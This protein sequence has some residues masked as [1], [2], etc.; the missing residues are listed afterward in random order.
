MPTRRTFLKSAFATFG[1]LSGAEFSAFATTTPKNFEGKDVFDRILRKAD[2]WA[3]LPIGELMGKI[4][5]E[6]EGTPYVAGS[7]ELSLDRE[8]CSVN[9]TGLDCVTFFETTLDFA[10]MIKKGGRTPEDLLKQVEFTRYRGGHRGDYS[11]RL[12]Y[13][14]DWLFDNQA[15]HTVKILD[16]L[17]GSTPYSPHVGFMSDHPDSYKQL[18]KHPAL[19][20]KLK[21]RENIINSRTLKFVPIDKI[22]EAAPSLKTG[23]IVGVCTSTPGLDITHTGL[24]VCDES[25]VPRFMHASSLKANYKVMVKPDLLPAALA[26]TKTNTGAMFARPLE[27]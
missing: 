14:S 2:K 16:D 13:T 18:A 17:P 5:K 27:P 25:G 26:W 21:Q 19:I 12:H 3:T 22:A 15:K 8:I 23:D 10:R 7:L 6:F 24:I 11:T 1:L 20:E 9:L 4:A